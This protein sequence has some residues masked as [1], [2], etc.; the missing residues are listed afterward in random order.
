[1]SEK[2]NFDSIFKSYDPPEG[3]ISGLHKKLDKLESKGSLFSLPK[4]AFASAFAAVIILAVLFYPG[5]LKPKKNLFTDLVS[6][7]DNPV[8]IKYGYIK[9]EA[10]GVTIPDS[11]K[12]HLAALRV[13]TSNKN[14][15]FYL[16]ESIN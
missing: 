11:E 10:E 7:S 16:I 5:L 13:E 9:K 12:T 2:I 1:M 15:K 14:V 4:I 6:K 3:G 8:F